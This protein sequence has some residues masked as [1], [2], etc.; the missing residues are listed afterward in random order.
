MML[1]GGIT[2]ECELSVSL[3]TFQGSPGVAMSSPRL[4]FIIL[5]N[6]DLFVYSDD[7]LTS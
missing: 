3:L 2:H 4:C 5:L 1:P 6:P 7:S